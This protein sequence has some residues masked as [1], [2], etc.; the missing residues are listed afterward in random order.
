MPVIE[1]FEQLAAFAHGRFGAEMAVA[2]DEFLRD[3]GIIHE[4]DELFEEFMKAFLDWFLFERVV[5][6]TD[7]TPLSHLLE[8]ILP[9]LPEDEVGIYN[10]F[11]RSNRSLFLIKKVHNETIDCQ[12][13]FSGLKISVLE[14]D[15]AGFLKGEIFEGRVLLFG[16]EMR[17]CDVLH[18]HPPRAN[19][20]I[21]KAVKNIK[22]SE[23]P[24]AKE[25]MK[26]LVAC[27]VKHFRFP[28]IDLL[29]FYKE[30]LP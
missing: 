20:I 27:K 24:G 22:S 4:S 30:I 1:Y 12:D 3:S 17:F 7:K 9:D 23:E 26:K 15:P 2:K 21:R 6:K 19:R 5:L 28:R 25:L 11:A 10:E 29:Q 18:F 14:K 16:G 13:L 8:Q